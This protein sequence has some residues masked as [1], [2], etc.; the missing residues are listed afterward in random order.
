[1]STSA[2]ISAPVAVV[3]AAGMGTRLQAVHADLPKGL[4]EIGGQP[5]MQ[6][7]VA[8]LRSAGVTDFVFVLGWK[9]EAYR[10]WC[11]RHCPEARCVENAAFASTGSL[12]SLIAGWLAVPPGR[13]VL[14]V[15]S[16]LLYERRAPALLLKSEA[17]DAILVSGFTKSGDEVW[18]QPKA[19]G[20]LAHL[21]KRPRADLPVLGELVGLTRLSAGL[22]RALEEAAATL[23]AQAHY[24]DGLN[25]LAADHPLS[26]VHAPD[27]R[28]C[29]IDDPAHL[30]RALRLVWPSIAAET[31]AP[32]TP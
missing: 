23:P 10:R 13:D 20:H 31:T 5:L 12:R 29:E 15:E 16:D 28:W 3:L 11:V 1:M 26:L 8:A 22:G 25:T 30:E 2:T 6:R 21:G 24:E 19:D 18:V 7:S 14:V 4:L 27:L 32:S 9:A 17:R